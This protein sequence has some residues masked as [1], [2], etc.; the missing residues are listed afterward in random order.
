MA[1]ISPTTS[2][3]SGYGYKAYTTTFTVDN[4][5]GAS[6][7][8]VSVS[9]GADQVSVDKASV[10]AGASDTVTVTYTSKSTT[11]GTAT[12]TAG[13]ATA[14]ITFTPSNPL[15]L[16]DSTGFGSVT[17]GAT[18]YSSIAL[19]NHADSTAATLSAAP[20]PFSYPALY[21]TV[22]GTASMTVSATYTPTAVGSD[23][24]SITMTLGDWTL[25]G[26]LTG[27]CTAAATTDDSEGDD[28]TET[29]TDVTDTSNQ[30]YF[31]SVPTETTVFNMGRKRDAFV[32]IDGFGFS[33]TGAGFVNVGDDYGLISGKTVSMQAYEDMNFTAIGDAVLSAKNSA[34]LFGNAGVNIGTL[35]AQPTSNTDDD[36][37]PNDDGVLQAK[38]YMADA[39][40]AFATLDT[41]LAAYQL[42][43]MGLQTK[44]AIE[45]GEA[46]QWGTKST[47][48]HILGLIA[49]MSATAISATNSIGAISAVAG[50]D[51][52][53]TI[54]ATIAKALPPITM[55]AEGGLLVGTPAFASYYAAAGMVLGSLYPL[56]FGF[57]TAVAAVNDL[58]LT[59]T[60]G[61]LNASGK[62]TNISAQDAVEIKCKTEIALTSQLDTTGVAS[63]EMKPATIEL[64]AGTPIKLPVMFS[65]IEMAKASLKSGVQTSKT[66]LSETTMTPTS[67]E[68]AVKAA[69][70]K[71]TIEQKSNEILLD[72]GATG[73]IVLQCGTWKITI[74]GTKGITFGQTNVASL[75][76][77]A[78]G[79][80]LATAAT[81][82]VKLTAA[83]VTTTAG[84]SS[85]KAAAAGIT[86]TGTMHSLG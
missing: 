59:A 14:T 28:S 15:S 69:A 42:I 86:Y 38:R 29:G 55:F 53:D 72:G 8:A 34:F 24:Q 49:G 4:S 22:P 25:T 63:I 83:D 74:D 16:P 82:S 32:K 30:S 68:N 64:K 12:L 47:I 17:L 50:T 7:V 70:I 39:M 43:T 33:T 51:E 79:A 52:G 73:K 61:E 85:I 78:G 2:P 60:N 62:E 57:D 1:T 31:I 6:A 65:S 37:M 19:Q 80:T 81:T 75:K 76:L 41:A 21:S 84:A 10:A 13:T 35:S 44:E 40:V 45:S 71:T 67:I 3:L 27:T 56:L 36:L 77:E 48:T 5:T 11:Q 58:S 26:T 18:S 23:S 66:I 54:A 20:A 9:G 46:K